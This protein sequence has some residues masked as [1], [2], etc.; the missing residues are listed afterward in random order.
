M[1]QEVYTPQAVNA[2]FDKVYI[3]TLDHVKLKAWFIHQNPEKS[4][5]KTARGMV[6][7]FHGNGEN[8]ST[9]FFSA[10]WLTWA[11]YDVL[12]FDYRGYG[13]SDSIPPDRI[14]V[15]RDGVAALNYAYKRAS[16]KNI[17]LIVLAQS[18]GGAVAIPSIALAQS[19]RVDALILD[20]T[21]AS[22]RS[23]AQDKLSSFWLTWPLQWPLS[24]LVSDDWSPIDF[25]DELSMPLLQLHAVHD[26][27]VPYSQ[28]RQLFEKI[29]SREKEFWDLRGSTHI[30]AFA[31]PESPYR[32][33]LVQWLSQK[34]QKYHK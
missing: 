27:V 14:G 4:Q 29:N 26:P 31:Y 10:A 23:I 11:G 16:A 7:Q 1:E 13:G 33:R 8:I 3:E 22:Y 21:F 30:A 25:A 34:N 9:H 20:S 5:L 32:E 18:L 28:G 6:L 2:T 12:S 24:F 15:L 17:P 19:V